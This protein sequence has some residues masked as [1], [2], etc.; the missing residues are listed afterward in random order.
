MESS[1]MDRV[2]QPVKSAVDAAK[3]WLGTRTWQRATNSN[4]RF[5]QLATYLYALNQDAKA[6][7]DLGAGVKCALPGML[8]LAQFMAEIR[9]GLDGWETA[10]AIRAFEAAAEGKTVIQAAPQRRGDDSP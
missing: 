1:V 6:L 8:Q 2:F 5:A 7:D 4:E 10:Q 3:D 9:A